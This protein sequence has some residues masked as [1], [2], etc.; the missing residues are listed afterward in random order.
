M[1]LASADILH[2]AKYSLSD[3]NLTCQ[4]HKHHHMHSESCL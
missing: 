2:V 4:L 3:L 1:I